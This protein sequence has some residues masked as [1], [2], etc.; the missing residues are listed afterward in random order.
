MIARRGLISPTQSEPTIATK[1]TGPGLR[2]RLLEQLWYGMFFA[3]LLLTKR[4]R[5]LEKH[6]RVSLNRQSSHETDGDGGQ[7]TEIGK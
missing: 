1:K 7:R 4:S 5:A 2:L 3:R 6:G